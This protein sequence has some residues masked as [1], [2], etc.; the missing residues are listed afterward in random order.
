[1][2]TIQPISPESM[3]SLT[4]MKNGAYRSTW[5]TVTLQPIC[6]ARSRIATHSLASGEI[7][8]S[9]RMSQPLSSA[10]IV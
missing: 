3:I 5:Q 1:M 6:S 8:F 2:A 10:A 4:R 7:G 9:S